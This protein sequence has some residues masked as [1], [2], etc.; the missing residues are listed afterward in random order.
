MSP[1]RKRQAIL[2][3]QERTRVSERRACRL[4]RQ[5]RTT[6]RYHGMRRDKDAPLVAAL[7]Q[8]S[9]QRP[10]AGYRMAAAYLRQDAS[11]SCMPL[12][13]NHT[14]IVQYTIINAPPTT[15]LMKTS[16]KK[17]WIKPVIKTVPIFFECTCYAGAV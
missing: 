5:P 11:A 9:E 2:H 14:T 17:R 6:Q 16:D 15:T 1:E 4:A 3:L 7:R 12:L 13:T 8:I 10:R